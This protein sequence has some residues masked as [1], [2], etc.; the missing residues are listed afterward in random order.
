MDKGQE[1]VIE[2]LFRG[3]VI[4]HNSFILNDQIDTDAKCKTVVTVY[5]I[6]YDT[7]KRLRKKIIELDYALRKLEI[8][9]IAMDIEP[10][11]D[12]IIVDPVCRTQF[13]GN[14]ATKHIIH[15]YEREL[16]VNKLTVKLKNAIMSQW[17]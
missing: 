12:Y 13:M 9:L 1:F 7:V 16:R 17:L 2:R 5:C 6:D 14:K 15:D 10:A 3:S 11:L 4:N 8:K